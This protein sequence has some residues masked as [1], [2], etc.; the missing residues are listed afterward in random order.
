M[1]DRRVVVL[2]GAL[3]DA[4]AASVSVFDRGFLFGEGVFETVRVYAGRAFLLARHLDRLVA[5]VEVMGFEV[6]RGMLEADVALALLRWGAAD[7]VL[8][9][10]VSGGQG[11]GLLPAFR[12]PAT[13]VV[14]IEPLPSIDQAIYERGVAVELGGGGL[15][16]P[17]VKS[18]SYAGSVVA[19]RQ[20]RERGAYELV[21]VDVEGRVLEGATSAV[22]AVRGAELLG[23]PLSLGVLPSLTRAALFELAPSLSLAPRECVLTR[24]MVEAADEVLLCSSIREV[25]PVV[26]V[27]G[28]PVGDGRV[29]PWAARL[30]TGLREMASRG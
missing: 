7:G 21:W 29:G 11:G 25:V 2:Q 13:R 4:E 1:V 24:Q 6:D 10:V 15:V 23:P 27:G 3:V 5:G 30:R 17:S 16:V 28:R 12:G 20:A 19:A 26:S 14:L 9:V 8:K 22:V 18:T